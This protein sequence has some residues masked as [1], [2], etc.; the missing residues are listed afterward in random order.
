MNANPSKPNSHSLNEPGKVILSNSVVYENS[1]IRQGVFVRSAAPSLPTS[2]I[3]ATTLEMLKTPHVHGHPQP[4]VRRSALVAASAVGL[5]EFQ[6]L[7]P[8]RSCVRKLCAPGGR[9]SIGI[10]GTVR[11]LLAIREF[12]VG[13]HP[14]C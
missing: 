13:R 14:L 4:Y 5:L 1:S 9:L 7:S 11:L 8:D 10:G 3:A 12:R 6:T 2:Q